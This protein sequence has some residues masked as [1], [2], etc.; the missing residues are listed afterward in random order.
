[1]TVLSTQISCA[2][3]TWNPATGCTKVSAGCDHCYA[4]AIA[5]RFFGGFDLTLHP[6]RLAQVTRFKPVERDG[7]RYP[8]LVFVNSMSD[9]WHR[10]IPD[11]FLDRV[12]DTIAG[13]P[14][15]IFQILT[16]RPQRMLAYALA[17]WRDAGVPA[18]V[19]LGVSVEDNRV[20]RRIDDLRRL[21][22]AAGDFTAYVNCEPLIGPVDGMDLT[23]ID[24]VL[25]GGESGPGARPV[26][27]RWVRQA[28]AGA[29]AVGAPVWFKQWGRWQHNPLWPQAQGRTVRAR[30]D[31]LVGRGLERMP[32]EHGGATLDGAVIQEFPASYHAA[33]DRLTGQAA[34]A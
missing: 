23:G 16:K 31:D 12:F 32:Q 15:A 17:R 8:R 18:N 13:R 1:M 14:D 2:D 20:R 21:K 27:A 5:R 6:E 33:A 30:R 4:E 19:W 26:E 34:A 25:I 28:I 10:D 11:A 24:W 22:A 7:R 3:S 29:R 9:L